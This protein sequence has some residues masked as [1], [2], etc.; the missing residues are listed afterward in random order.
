MG[1]ILSEHP[2]ILF[3]DRLMR[4]YV[5]EVLEGFK[6]IL[7]Y[8]KTGEVLNISLGLY[9]GDVLIKYYNSANIAWTLDRFEKRIKDIPRDLTSGELYVRVREIADKTFLE[10][11]DI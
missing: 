10:E 8:K 2:E 4:P 6:G 7:K 9:V 11:V 1:D 5:L 3:K